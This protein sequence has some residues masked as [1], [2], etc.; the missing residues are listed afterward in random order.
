MMSCKFKINI[1]Y[2]FYKI[3]FK[4]KLTDEHVHLPKIHCR[5]L[6]QILEDEHK[7]PNVLRH[8]PALYKI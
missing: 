7:V 6:A 2:F 3:F 4:I 5:L 8:V 1:K